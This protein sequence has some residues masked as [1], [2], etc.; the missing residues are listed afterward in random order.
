MHPAGF[1]KPVPLEGILRG[2]STRSSSLATPILTSQTTSREGLT[3]QFHTVFARDQCAR[4]RMEAPRTHGRGFSGKDAAFLR[5]RVRSGP[6]R[7]SGMD[8]SNEAQ[9]S[10]SARCSRAVGVPRCQDR[11]SRRESL[12]SGRLIRSTVANGFRYGLC[13]RPCTSSRCLPSIATWPALN[14]R[15]PHGRRIV[16]A[17]DGRQHVRPYTGADAFATQSRDAVPEI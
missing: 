9:G 4:V 5:P 7:M 13:H 17:T 6:G 8:R 10:G 15:G 3:R 14:Q 2:V 1:L 16:P 11:C 12:R